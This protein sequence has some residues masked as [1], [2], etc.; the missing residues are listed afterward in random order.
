MWP[1]F[2]DCHGV[3]ASYVYDVPPEEINSLKW[4]PDTIR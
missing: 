4:P 1:Q 2:V 3:D